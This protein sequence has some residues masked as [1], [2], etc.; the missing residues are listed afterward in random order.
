[1]AEE[2]DSSKTEEPTPRRLQQ[3]RDE[4]RIAVSQDVKAWAVLAAATAVVAGVAQYGVGMLLPSLLPFIDTPEQIAL[5]VGALGQTAFDL[6]L[7]V[8]WALAPVFLVLAVSSAASALVQSGLIWAPGKIAPDF[9]KISPLKGFGRLFSI[10]ALVEFAKSLLKLV[11][12][13][14]I[15]VAATIP[16]LTDLETLPAVPLIGTLGRLEEL[17][18]VLFATTTAVMTV[19][20]IGDFLHQRFQFLKQMRMTVQE[21]RD[22]YKQSEGDPQIKARIR[23]LRADRARQ[24]M[25]AEVPKADVVI[26]NPTHFAVAL[27]YDM[28]TMTAPKLVAKGVDHLAFRIRALAEA[29]AVPIVENPPLARALHAAVELDDEIPP[30]HYQAVAEIIGYI[31]GQKKRKPA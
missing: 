19:V 22:E 5:D 1:M 4:G 16:L 21:L 14:V 11:I 6:L 28:A 27:R 23:R 10:Q 18:I 24:R 30:E 15:G 26:T 25:M 13:G 29:N 31:M 8:L 17:I 7:V 3:L 20:A 2:D 12:V 9:E